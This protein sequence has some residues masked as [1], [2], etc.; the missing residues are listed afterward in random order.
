[1]GKVHVWP[2]NRAD[3]A[4]KI[5]HA[6]HI[7]PKTRL[8]SRNPLSVSAPEPLH[9][10]SHPPVPDAI[11][12]VPRPGRFLK[13][14]AWL[15]GFIVAFI[16]ALMAWNLRPPAVAPPSHFEPVSLPSTT[17][18]VRLR[19][20][21]WNVWGLLWMTQRREER[22]AAVAREVAA[23]H[24]DLVGFQEAFVTEDRQRIVTALREIGLV[25]H[26]YFSSGLVGSGL[27]IV[28]RYPIETDGFIRYRKNGHPAKLIQ[29]DWWAGKGLSLSLL[30]LPNGL[31]LYFADTHF[32]AHYRNDSV[33]ALRVQHAQSAQLVPWVQRVRETGIPALWVGDWNS[34]PDTDITTPLVE[35]G[36][37]Q[38]LT[39]K[40]RSIDNIF[41]SGDGWVWT[42]LQE[43]RVA[44]F[45]DGGPRTP[46]SDHAGRWVDV[47]LRR[48]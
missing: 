10:H 41:G 33:A 3:G 11:P 30:R 2:Q 38:L 47:E 15:L 9:N 43:G 40:Q 4:R 26:R 45:L 20:L 19:V 44:G 25:H 32:H 12:A 13:R 24:P 14:A 27:L 34:P 37:W 6:I 1:M 35:S 8:G 18:P 39:Q 36:H 28:S 5:R 23:I 21:T 16:L 17:E 31:P 29:G 42:I 46:W 7:S 22:L 48:P